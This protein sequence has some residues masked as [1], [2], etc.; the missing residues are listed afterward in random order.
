[1]HNTQTIPLELFHLESGHPGTPQ[2]CPVALAL[3]DAGY[4]HVVIGLEYATIHGSL[5]LLSPGV[6]S[7][8]RGLEAGTG[9]DPWRGIPLLRLDQEQ[10]MLAIDGEE[11]AD[12]SPAPGRL[13]RTWK[14]A[15]KAAKK[16]ALRSHQSVRRP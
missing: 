15:I 10:G 16:T 7:L 4:E 3:R 11:T 8:I 1:M 13:R 2:I 6:L 12:R 14:A 5:Y 9:P